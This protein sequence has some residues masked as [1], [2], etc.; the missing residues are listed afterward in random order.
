[1]FRGMMV[2]VRFLYLGNGNRGG[3]HSARI[4]RCFRKRKLQNTGIRN[5]LFGDGDAETIKPSRIA[6]EAVGGGTQTNMWTIDNSPFKT[7][8]FTSA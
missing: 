5:F 2:R 7:G 3:S 1:M 4:L 6:N 8:D